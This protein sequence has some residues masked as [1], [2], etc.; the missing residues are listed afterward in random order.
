MEKL[1]GGRFQGKSEAWID[2]FGAS[3][4]FDQKMA[5]EDLAGSLAHVAML[6]KCGII[7]A[8]EAAEI[9]AGLKILQEKLALGELEFSTVNEDIHLNIEKLLHEEIGP[10]AGKLHTAR[11]RND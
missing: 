2:D 8:S 4:S 7:P 5:K 11:S 9:T 1:W 3:I 6:S 10:V